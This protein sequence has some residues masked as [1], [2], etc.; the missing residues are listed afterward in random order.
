V[1]NETILKVGSI[2]LE[3]MVMIPLVAGFSVLFQ[4]LSKLKLWDQK[5]TLQ[6]ASDAQL[7]R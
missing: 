7:T 4:E 1:A 6:I 3:V 2:Q 5:Q